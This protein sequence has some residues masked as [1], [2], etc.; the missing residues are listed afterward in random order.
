MGCS[1]GIPGDP[2]KD[3]PDEIKDYKKDYRNIKFEVIYCST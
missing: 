1:Y 2:L 3:L